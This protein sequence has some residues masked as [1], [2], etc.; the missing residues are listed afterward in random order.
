L[1]DTVT[2]RLTN[3]SA[4][5]I[6]IVVNTIIMD[7]QA[8]FNEPAIDEI[9]ILLGSESRTLSAV[10]TYGQANHF[11]TRMIASS[12]DPQELGV[13]VTV[14]DASDVQTTSFNERAFWIK[15]FDEVQ[16][17]AEARRLERIESNGHKGH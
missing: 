12:G 3:R 9:F 10:N 8:H 4:D 2:I 17:N 11:S 16:K 5:P 14:T 15:S 13:D 1:D 6:D 7:H